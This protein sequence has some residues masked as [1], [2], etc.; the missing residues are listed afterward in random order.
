[1]GGFTCY[2]LVNSYEACRRDDLLPMPLSIGCRLKH[3]VPKDQP[4][5]Y[6]DVEV[7]KDRLCDKLRAEQT[8][9]FEEKRPAAAAVG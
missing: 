4:I 2:G 8:A 7:P 3:D 9:Y 5:S 1:M 6:R